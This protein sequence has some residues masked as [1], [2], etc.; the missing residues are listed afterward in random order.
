MRT[1]VFVGVGSQ[2]IWSA[3]GQLFGRHSHKG[4]EQEPPRNIIAPNF[5]LQAPYGANDQILYEQQ[6]AE[7]WCRF[8]SLFLV[9]EERQKTISR[10][11]FK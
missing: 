10:Y 3:F 9:F 5:S 2:K 8:M 4:Q 11:V 6:Y 7:I 1:A